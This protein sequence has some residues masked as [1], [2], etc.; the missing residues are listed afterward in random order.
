MSARLVFTDGRWQWADEEPG[1]LPDSICEYASRDTAV[2]VLA[3]VNKHGH[4][5]HQPAADARPR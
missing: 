5:E 4:P 3:Y 1:D 2:A